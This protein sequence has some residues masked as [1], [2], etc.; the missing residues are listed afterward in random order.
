M[1]D[2]RITDS[3]I[4]PLYPE[5]EESEEVDS[6]Q[7]YETDSSIG[8]DPGGDNIPFSTLK[9][10]S[11]RDIFHGDRQDILR[12]I[13]AGQALRS[14]RNGTIDL[15]AQTI[16]A[17]IIFNVQANNDDW[18][19]LAADHLGESEYVIR[20]YLKHGDDNVLLANLIH[21]TRQIIHALEERYFLAARS[22][23][24]LPTLIK[25]D[26]RNTL[27]EL[28]D[29]FLTL[30]DEINQE[31]Q[32]EMISDRLRGLHE[33]LTQGGSLLRA[34]PS[35][36]ST[37]KGKKSDVA[38]GTGL[39][40]ADGATNKLNVNALPFRPNSESL[41]F[42]H[43]LPNLGTSVDPSANS[44][45]K[46]KPKP[47]GSST[48][49]NPFFGNDVLKNRNTLVHVKDDFNIF[50]F[51]KVVEASAMLFGHIRESATCRCF[52]QLKRLHS[53]HYHHVLCR[54]HHGLTGI[55][56]PDQNNTNR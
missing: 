26:I 30:W 4:A 52:C 7:D 8:P 12:S 32:G 3:R 2:K 37:F 43:S 9:N 38:A 40:G 10:L 24:I 22:S 20:D 16:V 5:I 31:P 1:T 47:E 51:T 48:L 25:F 18:V 23:N 49:P 41:D 11:L 42:S 13:K 46:T 36:H 27:P 29:D 14:R 45:P 39:S 15:R 21:I 17:G 34:S 54:H 50:K 6:G 19:A 53:H 44:S 28:Q 56:E 35:A 33:V 55:V